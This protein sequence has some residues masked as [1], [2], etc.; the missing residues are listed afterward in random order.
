[1]SG[2]RIRYNHDASEWEVFLYKQHIGNLI[3]GDKAYVIDDNLCENANIEVNLVKDDDGYPFDKLCNLVRHRLDNPSTAR[4]MNDREL[5][6]LADHADYTKQDLRK[7]KFDNLRSGKLEFRQYGTHRVE[8]WLEDNL[9]GRHHCPLSKVSEGIWTV[10]RCMDPLLCQFLGIPPKDAPMMSVAM[11]ESLIRRFQYHK[12]RNIPAVGRQAL[13]R[14]IFRI[15][16]A[17]AFW[18]HLLPQQE[19]EFCL[20]NTG[21][22]CGIFRCGEFMGSLYEDPA[23]ALWNIG[24]GLHESLGLPIHQ[25]RKLWELPRL[26]QYIRDKMP[27]HAHPGPQK[28][29]ALAREQE[30]S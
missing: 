23:T 24:Y 25:D 1:M 7:L 13:Q 22:D 14:R 4:I 29:R 15:A 3:G 6:N 27:D 20:S 5:S 21:R 2:V 28:R 8:V 10:D 30:T 26:A 17:A 12:I 11:I 9:I 19:A 16:E 18:D